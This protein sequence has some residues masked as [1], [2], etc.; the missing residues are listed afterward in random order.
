MKGF[1]DKAFHAGRKYTALDF[2]IFKLCLISLGIL[3]GAY[4][5]H[6]FLNLTTLLWII[7]ILSYIFV[8]YRTFVKYWK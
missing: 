1:M 6:F 3:A 5:A 8:M 2:A 7:F 4:F